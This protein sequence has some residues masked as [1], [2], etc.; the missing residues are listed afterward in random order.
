MNPWG[1]MGQ[2]PFRSLVSSQT[3]HDK[4]KDLIACV[5]K[6]KRGG[7]KRVEVHSGQAGGQYNEEGGG[8]ERSSEGRQGSGG[9]EGTRGGGESAGEEGRAAHA[10]A[11]ALAAALSSDCYL[12]STVR[13]PFHT[14]Y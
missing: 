5:L 2:I 8:G 9:N 12:V 7:E 1:T 3:S 6:C 13:C 11:D 10:D 4:V 14:S